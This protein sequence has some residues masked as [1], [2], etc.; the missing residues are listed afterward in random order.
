[1]PQPAE[2][3][4]IRDE[5]VQ[6]YE[7]AWRSI[8]Q[9]LAALAHQSP[10][11]VAVLRR[12][13]NEISADIRA[14]MDEL[15][16]AARGWLQ[17]RLPLVYQ[18]GGEAAAEQLGDRFAWAQHHRAALQQ[19]ART[20][21]DDLLGATRFV[22][23]DVKRLTREM[24]RAET[25]RSIVEGRTA[26]RAGRSLAGNLRQ[27]FGVE[28]LAAVRYSNGARH[29]LA[30]YADTVLRTTTATAFNQ[31]TLLTGAEAGVQWVEI[32][33]GPDCGWTAHDDP[34]LANGSIRTLDEA[35]RQALAH[36]RCARAFGLRPDIANKTQAK[37]A[38]RF[39]P[40]QRA[41]MAAAERS[42][43]AAQPRRFARDQGSRR[44]QTVRARRQARIAKTGRTPAPAQ[45]A[46]VGPTGP[47]VSKPIDVLAAG[48]VGRAVDEALNTIDAVHGDGALPPIPL[49]SSRKQTPNG[50]YSWF[51]TGAPA[52][53]EVSSLGDHPVMTTVH[54]VGHFLDHHGIGVAGEFASKTAELTEW[55]AAVDASDAVVQLRGL[56]VSSPLPVNERYRR[57]LLKTEELWARSYAQYVAT[58]SGSQRMLGELAR[59]VERPG[60]GG[61]YYPAQWDGD[62]FKPIAAAIDKLFA[63]LGWRA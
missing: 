14:S 22:R 58:T 8:E 23:A 2:V 25:I 33:D 24:A 53:I 36:P 60:A 50:S 59:L 27:V 56:R 13:L 39:T 34:D 57:Y 29:G 48:Q 1:M 44:R 35:Q 62:D 41:E 18:L 9:Q 11:R 32:F 43:A 10:D 16:V 54:E 12:R 19:L 3:A 46:P 63:R 49:K 42:R 47:T 21:F 51:G 15:D 55:R 5:L 37:N 30:D 6:I 26:A 28:P 20:S 52:Q 7:N 17:L 38:D 61:V 45:R 40:E 4:A 31:G